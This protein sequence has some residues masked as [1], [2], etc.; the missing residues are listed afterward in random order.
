M[1]RFVEREGG[2]EEPGLRV[3]VQTQSWWPW[4]CSVGAMVWGAPQP[5][6]SFLCRGWRRLPEVLPKRP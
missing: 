6:S 2:P 4:K 1:R 3:Q 5:P